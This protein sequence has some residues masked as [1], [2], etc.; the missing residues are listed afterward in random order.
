MGG[1]EE[2]QSHHLHWQ[3][4]VI[5]GLSSAAAQTDRDALSE[6]RSFERAISPELRNSWDFTRFSET[7]WHGVLRRLQLKRAHLEHFS[8]VLSAPSR[9]VERQDRNVLS[10][11]S[12]T[13]GSRKIRSNKEP[14]YSA[15]QKCP[16]ENKNK[17]DCN[18]EVC[19]CS[20]L[21]WWWNVLFW[22][23]CLLKPVSRYA[24]V[25]FTIDWHA[26]IFKRPQISSQA[27]CLFFKKYWIRLTSYT[28]CSFCITFSCITS[29]IVLVGMSHFYNA[30]MAPKC[31]LIY[32]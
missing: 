3:E 28:K 12:Q 4:I 15:I 11:V 23:N 7:T 26:S 6:L 22:L 5:N 16:H 14:T 32:F 19:F 21:D 13:D 24:L 31:C 9:T 20:G 30:N 1:W 17:L 29:N 27:C 10:R 18:T 25:K 2:A 8:W